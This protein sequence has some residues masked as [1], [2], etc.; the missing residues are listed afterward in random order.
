MMVAPLVLVA[1]PACAQQPRERVR[2][3]VVRLT[4][5]KDAG[6]SVSLVLARNRPISIPAD[7]M[8]DTL[9][10]VGD[11]Q[12]LMRGTC[13]GNCSYGPR[14]KIQPHRA[15][16]Y[17]TEADRDSGVVIAR[18]IN[19]DTL[20]YAKFNLHPRDTVY[21][22]VGRRRGELVSV[23]ISSARGARPWVSDLAIDEH[24]NAPYRQPLARWLWDDRDELTWGTCDGGR[25]CRSTGLPLQ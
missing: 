5:A 18:I 10:G 15:A 21:W 20:A 23:F 8:F 4:A 6:D 3:A 7:T 16:S 12:R 9:P 14:A 17:L 25:C 13:P 19:L 2:A 1:V 22:W 11:D 24:Q